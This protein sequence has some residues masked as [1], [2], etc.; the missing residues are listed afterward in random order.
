MKKIGLVL[1]GAILALTPW[2]GGGEY[3]MAASQDIQHSAVTHPAQGKEPAT[4]GKQEAIIVPNGSESW[5]LHKPVQQT[6]QF[7]A[8]SD[9]HLTKDQV[10]KRNQE[11]RKG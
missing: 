10:K 1:A 11:S 7:F 5:V 6:L 2:M 3:V 8:I 9:T 4:G